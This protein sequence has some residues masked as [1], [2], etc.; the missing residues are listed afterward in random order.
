MKLLHVDSSILG[1]NSV[2]RAISAAV[3]TRLVALHPELDVT[4]RDLAAA[5]LTHL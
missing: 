5:P 2:S 1:A 3:T 4:Y